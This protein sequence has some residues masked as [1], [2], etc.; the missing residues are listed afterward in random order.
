MSTPSRHPARSQKAFDRGLKRIDAQVKS[1]DEKLKTFR[2]LGK[3][4][5]RVVDRIEKQ[6][7]GKGKK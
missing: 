4:L 6:S 2:K 5:D 3:E 7:N 1:T